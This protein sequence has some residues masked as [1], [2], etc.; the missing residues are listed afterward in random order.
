MGDE[1]REDLWAVVLT[2]GGKYIGCFP[3]DYDKKAVL[4]AIT[5]DSFVELSL[6]YEINT[7]NIPVPAGGGMQ[8]MRQISS[9]PFIST[10]DEAPLYLVVTGVQFL[11]D[12]KEADR[13]RYK[14]L[15][16]EA[17]KIAM[18][19]R[20]RSAGLAIGGDRSA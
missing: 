17:G 10:Y 19:A 18:E 1:Q 14:G 6:A 5:R 9:S 3:K 12:M 8:I 20:A 2:F 13:N 16:E 4:A 15:V 7:H 11:S